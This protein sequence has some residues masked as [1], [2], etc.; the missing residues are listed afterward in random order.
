MAQMNLLIFN[1]KTDAKDSILGFTTDWINALAKKCNRVVIITM[2]S[3]KISVDDNVTVYSVGKEKGYSELR[4]LFEFYR[5]LYRV[6]QIEKID[7]CFA[8]MMPLFAVL[9]FPLLKIRKIPIVLWYTHKSITV[10]LKLAVYCSDKVITAAHHSFRIE[11]PKKKVVGHG[12][13]TNRFYLN[14]PTS[15]NNQFRIISVGRIMPVKRLDLLIKLVRD[16]CEK[17]PDKEISLD[18]VGDTYDSKDGDKYINDLRLLVEKYKLNNVVKFTGSVPFD[19]VN[20]VY[21]KADCFINMSETGGVDKAVLEAMACGVVVV[22]NDSFVE[23]LGKE[24]STNLVATDKDILKKVINILEMSS[25]QRKILGKELREIV[26]ND[27]SLSAIA[28]KIIHEVKA[29]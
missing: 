6:L 21:K 27:H 2:A 26:I 14:T 4:R 24:I 13:D 29:H 18:L 1:L 22:V 12:I 23:I 7:G 19:N 11:T 15:H 28:N 20:K 17:F 9:G 25:Q 8:H 16:L 10:T 5:I 3:G